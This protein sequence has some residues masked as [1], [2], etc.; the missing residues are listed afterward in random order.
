MIACHLAGSQYTRFF[1]DVYSRKA[2]SYLLKHLFPL[3]LKKGSFKL[4]EAH[5]KVVVGLYLSFIVMIVLFIIQLT[6]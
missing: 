1:T 6:S 5:N 2:Q 3:P 4:V